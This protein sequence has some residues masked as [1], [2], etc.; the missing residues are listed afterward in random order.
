MNIQQRL[1]VLER[2]TASKQQ[3]GTPI[4]PPVWTDEQYNAL[5][6]GLGIR[7]KPFNIMGLGRHFQEMYKEPIQQILSDLE[8]GI[9]PTGVLVQAE[10]I[11]FSDVVAI[12]R[13]KYFND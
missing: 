6:I 11:E 13:A 2:Q 5:I 10:P 7:N 12:D 3:Y 8:H 1:T 9:K 4:K